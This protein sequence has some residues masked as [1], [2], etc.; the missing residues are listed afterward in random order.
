MSGLIK[1]SF[2]LVF[3]ITPALAGGGEGHIPHISDILIFWV[4]FCIFFALLYWKSNKAIRNAWQ[5]RRTNIEE[6]VNKGKIELS[7]AKTKL[8][9]VRTRLSNLDAEVNEMGK[10]ISE[11]TGY[12]IKEMKEIT[13][14][15]LSR[16]EKQSRQSIE[17]EKV[18]AFRNLK[19]ELADEIVKKATIVIK[20]KSN[21]GTDEL[22]RK[23]SVSKLENLV[24]GN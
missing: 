8:D 15:E 1:F 21:L 14:S 2:L 7:E 13:D 4:N 5:S 20:E 9:E 22:R 6:A 24:R 23:K 18:S 16:I 17:A 19:N 10:V 12:E 3:S 11:E